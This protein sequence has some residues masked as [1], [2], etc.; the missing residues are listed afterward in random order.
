MREPPLVDIV[1][2]MESLAPLLSNLTKLF[3]HRT[4][5]TPKVFAVFL[6]ALLFN[7]G[8]KGG[9]QRNGHFATDVAGLSANY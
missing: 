5:H 8:K 7:I 4:E 3:D 9:L 1:D 6:H 2:K